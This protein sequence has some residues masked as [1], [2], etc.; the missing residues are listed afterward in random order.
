[1]D[2]LALAPLTNIALLL[3]QYPDIRKDIRRIVL[4]GGA[5]ESGNMTPR[6]EF[7]IYTDAEAARIVFRSGI[8]LTMIGI[9]VCGKTAVTAADMEKLTAH[10]GKAAKFVADMMFYPGDAAHPFPEQGIL[11]YDALAAAALIDPGCVTTYPYYVDV[12]TKGELTYGETVV[13]VHGFL[14]KEPNVDVAMESDTGR[15]LD[16]MAKT[17]AHYDGE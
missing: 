14:K 9:D 10:G 16:L 11:I 8:P 12:E 3:L 7:N 6:T 2:I 4:M 5:V 17:I 13:D 1:M 15:F